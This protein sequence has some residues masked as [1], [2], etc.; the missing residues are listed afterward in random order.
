MTSRWEPSSSRR[1]KC[2][3]KENVMPL[4]R[5]EFDGPVAPRGG[6]GSFPALQDGPISQRLTPPAYP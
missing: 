2:C 4:A 3:E 6:S 5:L 1:P